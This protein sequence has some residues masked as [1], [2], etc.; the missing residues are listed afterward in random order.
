MCF[1]AD[2]F[3]PLVGAEP[4]L[5]ISPLFLS[6][7]QRALFPTATSSPTSAAVVA[8]LMANGIGYLYADSDHPNRLISTASLVARGGDVEVLQ[9]Q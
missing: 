8:F 4:S 9:I 7:P 3:A 2:P 5:G 6:A 1:E